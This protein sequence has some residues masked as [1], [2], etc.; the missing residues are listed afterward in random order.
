M[1]SFSAELELWSEAR[2]G[3]VSPL[4][5]LSRLLPITLLIGALFKFILSGP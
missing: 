5:V 2:H 3:R 1:W 4:I